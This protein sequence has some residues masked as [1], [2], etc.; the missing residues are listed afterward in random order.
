MHGDAVNTAS[1]I[2]GMTKTVGA[3]ILF[4]EA[5]RNAFV[6]P[7]DDLRHLGE[8]EVRGRDSTVSLWTVDDGV[9]RA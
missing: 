2:E 4:S 8:H 3:P 1:R 9:P 7:P 6:Q 5:T